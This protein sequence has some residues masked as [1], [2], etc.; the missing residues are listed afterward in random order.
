MKSK[1]IYLLILLADLLW[2]AASVSAGDLVRYHGNWNYGLSSPIRGGIYLLTLVSIAVWLL[3][4]LTMDLDCFRSGW[5]ISAMISRT[6]LATLLLF[7]AVLSWGYFARIYYSRL[8]LFYYFVFFWAGLILIRLGANWLLR[9]QVRA[10]NVRRVVLIGDYQLSKEIASRIQRHPE[11]LY[12]I[13]GFLTPHEGAEVTNG[14]APADTVPGLSSLD[15]IGFL[16]KRDVRELIVLSKHAP[17][18]DLQKFLVGCQ[19]EGIHIHV[20]PQPYELYLSRPRLV[21]VDGIPLVFLQHPKISLAA[22][23]LKRA[24]DLVTA[25]VLLIPATLAIAVAGGILWAKDRHFLRKETRCG[26]GGQPFGM[27]RLDIETE[28]EK[29]SA[30]HRLLRNLSLSELPQLFNVLAGQMSLVG[31]RPEP[32]ERVRDYSEWQKQRLKILPGM[33]GLAQVNGLREE[34]PSED[35]TRYDLQ[36]V[37]HWSPLFDIVLLLQTIWTLVGRLALHAANVRG[38]GNMKPSP[39]PKHGSAQQ[40]VESAGE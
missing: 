40:A 2:M 36:Y 1:L 14:D 21:E 4:Y 22:K 39:N 5:Q 24:F 28:E 30:Y 19:E 26:L 23:L 27:Y 9:A 12:Q 15:A 10:G 37:L 31:P 29:A 33:T 16:L 11:F 18:L 34:H 6:S 7:S 35:K 8:M 17:G 32:L 20:L 13:V 38:A 25:M 3:L